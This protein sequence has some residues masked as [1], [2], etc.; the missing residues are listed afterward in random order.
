MIW[1]APVIDTTMENK[2]WCY[3]VVSV[4]VVIITQENGA[5]LAA[6]CVS[7]HRHESQLVPLTS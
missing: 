4:I 5:K 3:Y 7:V 1:T 2:W 6:N